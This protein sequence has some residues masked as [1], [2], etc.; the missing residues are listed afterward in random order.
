MSDAQDRQHAGAQG[1]LL[2]DLSALADGQLDAEQ[3]ARACGQW[4]QTAELRQSWHA[5]H[6]IG[7]VMR[8]ED[9]AESAVGDEA[10]LKQLRAR[11]AQEPVV[12]APSPEPLAAWQ[13]LRARQWLA[14]AAVAASFVAVATAFV[15]LR[16]QD[17]PGGSS[18]GAMLAAT[19]AQGQMGGAREASLTLQPVF[20]A[21]GAALVSGPQG[22]PVWLVVGAQSSD[23]GWQAVPVQVQSDA[24]AQSIWLGQA[25]VMPTGAVLKHA[26]P[27]SAAASR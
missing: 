15:G 11:M 8:S 26:M 6:V 19:T 27:V 9:L 16:T 24:S 5:W 17:A 4:R 18:S 3:A 14:P 20:D 22:Q 7:D 23:R 2:S 10:F 25:T 13:R 1:Q 12:L 21:Q